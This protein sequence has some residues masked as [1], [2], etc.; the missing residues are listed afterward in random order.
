MPAFLMGMVSN[1][2]LLSVQCR[3][4][5]HDDHCLFGDAAGGYATS[6]WL[7]SKLLTYLEREW[8]GGAA[9]EMAVA[10]AFLQADAKVLHR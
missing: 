6:E 10:E 8:D 1:Q 4:G 9:P 7:A 5:C 3:H 2:V